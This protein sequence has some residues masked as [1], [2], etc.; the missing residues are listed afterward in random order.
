M[1]SFCLARTRLNPLSGLILY[2]DWWLF[3]DSPSSP[4]TLWSA[5]IKWPNFFCSKYCFTSASSA[6]SPCDFG[7]QAYI[8]SSICREVSKNSVLVFLTS[9]LLF[10][11][12]P[13]FRPK[14]L[15]SGSSLNF[16]QS[17][18][19][20]HVTYILGRFFFQSCELRQPVHESD[21][22]RSS[23]TFK[24]SFV[25]C[26]CTTSSTG[27]VNVV[28]WKWE[29]FFFRHVEL[30]SRFAGFSVIFCFVC[31]LTLF[32][33]SLKFFSEIFASYKLVPPQS[34]FSDSTASSRQFCCS[35]FEWEFEMFTFFW[36]SSQLLNICNQNVSLPNS[37][38]NQ[39]IS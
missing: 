32:R 26:S 35:V 31:R 9:E 5:V 21:K 2:H 16:Y 23:S 30:N 34:G 17:P 38:R 19:G 24:W 25:R 12:G 37:L 13:Y 22:V 18:P 1:K 33:V 3:R 4:R 8:A 10:H 20:P 28:Q 11:F 6:R 14:V 27:H 36:T 15:R 39:C 7:G 29:R